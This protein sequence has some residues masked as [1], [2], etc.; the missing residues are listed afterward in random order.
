LLQ[1]VH[2]VYLHHPVEEQRNLATKEVAY[3]NE[4]ESVEFGKEW[5]SMHNMPKL[6]QFSCCTEQITACQ[7]PPTTSDLEQGVGEGNQYLACSSAIIHW[8]TTSD[9]LHE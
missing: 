4:V 6:M 3:H 7:S 9:H 1:P 5:F 8:I 2:Q